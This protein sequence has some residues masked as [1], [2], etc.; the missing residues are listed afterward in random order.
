MATE[1]SGVDKDVSPNEHKEKLDGECAS[2][3]QCILDTNG[4]VAQVK[5]VDMVGCNLLCSNL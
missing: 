2:T 4:I 1:M 3:R 5:S